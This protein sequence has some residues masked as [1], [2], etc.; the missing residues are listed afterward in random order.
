MKKTEEDELVFGLIY[1]NTLNK[2]ISVIIHPKILHRPHWTK[3][4]KKDVIS[5]F[6]CKQLTSGGKK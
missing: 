2:G 5:E 3:I 6:H 1:Y 4:I